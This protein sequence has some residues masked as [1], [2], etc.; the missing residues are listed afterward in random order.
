MHT[1]FGNINI[2]KYEVYLYY[3]NNNVYINIIKYKKQF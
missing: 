2:D 3:I 1:T